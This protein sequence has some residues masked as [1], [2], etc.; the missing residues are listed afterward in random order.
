A[1]VRRFHGQP[2]HRVRK[3]ERRKGNGVF[4]VAVVQ[5]GVVMHVLELADGGDVA[6]PGRFDVAVLLALDRQQVADLER[7]APVVDEY[8][9][10]AAQRALVHAEHAQL[11]YERIVDDLEHVGDD[12]F[13]RVGAGVGRSGRF[14]APAHERRRVAFGRGGQQALGQFQQ[15][16]HARTGARGHETDRHQVAFAQALLER[17]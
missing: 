13:V 4:V 10:V 5:Y 15:R 6:R 9:R 11:A 14:A 1:L 3:F 16:R 8:L 7:L 2:E 12:V 17:V